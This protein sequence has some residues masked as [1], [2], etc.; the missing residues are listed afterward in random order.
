MKKYKYSNK[1]YL[2]F[3]DRGLLFST[4][5]KVGKNA[6]KTNG[7]GI[8]C[9]IRTGI[10]IESRPVCGSNIIPLPL[11]VAYCDVPGMN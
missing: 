3:A 7:F 11:P 4:A 5:R 1:Y 2:S 9:S 6:A 10:L 8:L